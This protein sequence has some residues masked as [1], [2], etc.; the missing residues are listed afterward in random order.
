MTHKVCLK[1][2]FFKV[3]KLCLTFKN[4]IIA[5]VKTQISVLNGRSFLL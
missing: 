5:R 4:E 2:I 1:K 3:L